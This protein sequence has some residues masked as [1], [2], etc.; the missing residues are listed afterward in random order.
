MKQFIASVFLTALITVGAAGPVS[1]G[2][3]RLV[4]AEEQGCVWC[5]RWN[6]EIA[7]K[8]PKTPEGKAAPLVRMD[9][10][11]TRPA[12]Y[13][14]ARRISYTPTFLLMVN[15]IEV[16]RIEGYPGEDFFWPLLADM[17]T[18]AGIDWKTT[19]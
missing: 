5:E 10:H 9:I 8:Y 3:I 7:A 19:G 2:D 1:A 6:T 4:M 15:G 16:S 11:G 14:F 17:L 18:R 12:G 13:E